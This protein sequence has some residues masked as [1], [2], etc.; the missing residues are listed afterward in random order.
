MPKSLHLTSRL[1]MLFNALTPKNKS[2]VDL[3]FTILYSLVLYKTY[4]CNET[5]A[6]AS[7][8]LQSVFFH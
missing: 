3:H 5:S 2:N 4:K 7:A 8:F 1:M 6:F